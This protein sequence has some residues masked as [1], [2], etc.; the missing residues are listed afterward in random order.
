MG[1]LAC[2]VKYQVFQHLQ[3]SVMPSLSLVSVS[4]WVNAPALEA[5]PN[6]WAAGAATC[7][8]RLTEAGNGTC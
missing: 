5:Q 8:Q 2:G 1:L 7:H 4:L 6:A 3:L